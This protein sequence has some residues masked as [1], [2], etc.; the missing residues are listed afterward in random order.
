VTT[1]TGNLSSGKNHA[2]VSIVEAKDESVFIS[3]GFLNFESELEMIWIHV[4]FDMI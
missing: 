1:T 3:A 2:N 4:I